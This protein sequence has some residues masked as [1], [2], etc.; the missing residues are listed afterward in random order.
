[1]YHVETT[2]G[3]ELS[4]TRLCPALCLLLV[5]KL[6][7]KQRHKR[8]WAAWGSFESRVDS[9]LTYAEVGIL[10]KNSSGKKQL[11]IHHMPEVV[12]LK[13]TNPQWSL[14]NNVWPANGTIFCPLG[15][16]VWQGPL[17]SNIWRYLETLLLITTQE[18]VLQ[19]LVSRGQ[20]Y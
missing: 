2:V 19:L 9:A 12:D 1:M 14:N 6:R 15:S 17:P 5:L 3:R 13:K 18:E 20:G 7:Q 4:W 10:R 8:P 11:H 16:G